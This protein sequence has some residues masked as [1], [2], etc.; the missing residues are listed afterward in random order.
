MLIFNEKSSRPNYYASPLH[1]ITVH[2]IHYCDKVEELGSV[3]CSI[4]ITMFHLIILFIPFSTRTVIK[5]STWALRGQVLK[6]ILKNTFEF[7]L[8]LPREIAGWM[9]HWFCKL[10][11]S[12]YSNWTLVILQYR[13]MLKAKSCT[14]RFE[15]LVLQRSIAL[16]YS[17]FFFSFLRTIRN[18]L[19]DSSSLEL[20]LSRLGDQF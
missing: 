2:L 3:K 15:T 20:L 18:H 17:L 13:P 1:D 6:Q 10:Y 8:S 14:T 7:Q 9:V 11:V 4:Q 16:K 19:P 5:N 12:N